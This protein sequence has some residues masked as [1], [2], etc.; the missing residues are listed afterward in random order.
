M[1]VCYDKWLE[2]GFNGKLALLA[3][4]SG[5]GGDNLIQSIR[6]QLNHMGVI[7]LPKTIIVN[8]IVN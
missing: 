6:I 8:S 5:G 7:I 2:I 3:S 1:D 4:Y